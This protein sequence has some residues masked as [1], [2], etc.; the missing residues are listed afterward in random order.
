[1]TREARGAHAFEVAGAGDDAELRALLRDNP[2][3]GWLRL[4]LEREP[5]V[6]ATAGLYDRHAIVIAR[7]ARSGRAVG[8][9]EYAVR[10]MY[11]DGAV[12]CVPYLGALRVD[13]RDRHRIALLRQGFETVRTRLRHAADYPAALT[14]I[15]AGNTVARRVLCAGLAGLPRYL[16]AGDL[17]TLALATRGSRFG[18]GIE[19]AQEEDLPAIAALL[20]RTYRGRKFAPHWTGDDLLALARFALPAGRFLVARD[21]GAIRGCIAVWD[22]RA[23]KQTRVCGYAPWVAQL[24]PLYNATAWL[25]RVPALPRA[26]ETLDQVYLSHRAADGD[27][28]LLLRELVRAGL[29]FARRLGAKVAL[30]GAATGSAELA[31]LGT[32]RGARS[33]RSEL[34]TVHWPDATPIQLPQAD[35]QPEIALL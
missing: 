25:T 8:L 22:Q 21:G 27:D 35:A 5:D 28:P 10:R 13:A 26:G 20:Q 7:E 24:R 23:F 12:H 29:A 34:F 31:A 19:H 14:S 33:Y 30:L 32:L 16:P 6:F 11:V 17:T 18:P 1:M 4:S 2:I 15:S 3:G 9:C